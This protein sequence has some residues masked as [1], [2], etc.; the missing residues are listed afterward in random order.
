VTIPV[1]DLEAPD[2]AAVAGLRWRWRRETRP[3]DA[4]TL[5]QFAAAFTAWWDGHA[6]YEAVVADDNGRIVA[7]G[8]LAIVPRVPWPEQ[9]DRSAGDL[10][11][12]YVVPE[13][14]GQGLGARLVTAL[15]E[16][17]RSRGCVR[18]TVHSARLAVPLYQRAGFACVE[19]LLTRALDA[20]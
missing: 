18:V 8:F 5:E 4:E 13:L 11:S 14:R 3:D 10:Q 2:L 19:H 16:R 17:A 9:H 20:V 7:M 6:G 1:R 12:V 15:V